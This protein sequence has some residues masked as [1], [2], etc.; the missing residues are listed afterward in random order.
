MGVA[1]A[2]PYAPPWQSPPPGGAQ[3]PVSI[4][5]NIVLPP[6]ANDVDK[7]V[8]SDVAHSIIESNGAGLARFLSNNRQQTSLSGGGYSSRNMNFPGM[9][10]RWAYNQGLEKLS[11]DVYPT[12]G[13]VTSATTSETNLDGYVA[14]IHVEP[15]W[16]DEIQVYQQPRRSQAPGPYSILFNGYLIEDAY[17]PNMQATHAG[18]YPILFGK[19]ALLCDSYVGT[20]ENQNPVIKE[21]QLKKPNKIIAPGVWGN[22][23]AG[24]MPDGSS[25][26][27]ITKTLGYWLFDWLNE[28]NP[29]QY[30]FTPANLSSAQNWSNAFL[31]GFEGFFAGK[32]VF[33]KG[34]YFADTRLNKS[35]LKPMGQ[36]GMCV[37]P[38]PGKL[39][40]VDIEVYEMFLGE[41]YDRGSYRVASQSWTIGKRPRTTIA[42]NDK[43]LVYGQSQYYS[44]YNANSGGGM[45]F[46]LDPNETKKGPRISGGGSINDDNAVGLMDYK[47]PINESL[48]DAGFHYDGL[49][50]DEINNITSW[51][52]DCIQISTAFQTVQFAKVS[53]LS[54]QINTLQ[55]DLERA[56]KYALV[57]AT[58]AGDAKRYQKLFPGDYDTLY[59]DSVAKVH[60]DKAG[61]PAMDLTF[62]TG[63]LVLSFVKDV[64]NDNLF[65]AGPVYGPVQVWWWNMT[66]PLTT[67]E[68]NAVT[69]AL[70]VTTGGGASITQSPYYSTTTVEDFIT[71]GVPETETYLATLNIEPKPALASGYTP[72]SK[73]DNDIWGPMAP[74]AFLTLCDNQVNGFFN[75]YDDLLKQYDDA[76]TLKPPDLPPFPAV[77]M[78]LDSFK[79]SPISISDDQW[80]YEQNP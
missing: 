59:F 17:L 61:G 12:G 68:I 73:N 39:E 1:L 62:P 5:T 71:P 70:A 75:V 48:G 43:P 31:G 57:G 54:N 19:T 65:Y 67:F 28:H 40:A 4:Q 78:G 21:A 63:A 3:R 51:Q 35:P 79:H 33:D 49:T 24:S 8:L 37:I 16:P 25:V 58:I 9:S 14:W 26:S 77:G 29:W 22:I 47:G 72:D 69:G 46:T 76:I 36:N 2:D 74:S 23:N 53:S 6:D 60:Y 18:G 27:K 80:S 41:F 30:L 15:S 38:A 32:P 7:N 34:M 20:V 45:T 11:L 42:I 66:F 52:D 44:G 50:D 55:P 56:H 13:G 64:S 10:A